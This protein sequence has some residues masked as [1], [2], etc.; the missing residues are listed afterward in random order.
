M[1]RKLRNE[2][3]FRDENFG[4]REIKKYLEKLRLSAR[5]LEDV[6]LDVLEQSYEEDYDAGR[7][8]KQLH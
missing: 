3:M 5:E 4:I 7:R 1:A 6:L 2:D 8:K